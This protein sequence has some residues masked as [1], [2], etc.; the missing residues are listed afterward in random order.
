MRPSLWLP[1]LWPLLIVLNSSACGEGGG[2]A[3]SCD[4]DKQSIAA[5][6]FSLDTLPLEFCCVPGSTEEVLVG[7]IRASVGAEGTDP[8]YVRPNAT[9]PVRIEVREA[10][11]TEFREVPPGAEFTVDNDTPVDIRITALECFD[12]GLLEFDVFLYSKDNPFHPDREVGKIYRSVPLRRACPEPRP[13][14][15]TAVCPGTEEV[16]KVVLAATQAVSVAGTVCWRI[17]DGAT[18]ATISDKGSELG[19]PDS[20]AADVVAAA[21]I[22]AAVAIGPTGARMNQWLPGALAGTGGGAFGP[23]GYVFL[24]DNITDFVPYAGPG[25]AGGVF[26]NFT[27]G[28]VK[29]L[30]YDDGISYFKLHTSFIAAAA[31]PGATGK[32]I[33]AL[34]DGPDEDTFVVTDGTPGSLWVHRAADRPA[35][36]ATK[37]GDVEN[38]PR[39]LRRFGNLLVTSNFGSGS[40]TVARFDTRTIVRH[41]PVGNGPIGIDG[42]ILGNG[43]IAIVSTGFNDDTYTITVL[44]PQGDVVSSD[45]SPVPEGGLAPGHVIWHEDGILISCNGSSEIIF[46]PATGP[47]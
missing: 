3:C 6:E 8:L 28:E 34:A 2:P 31:L 30:V 43:Y 36:A 45:T 15:R 22:E 18:F 10:T 40:I 29:F 14:Q 9:V 4:P 24:S 7:T 26:S 19:Q 35:G 1:R 11:E 25:S 21:G 20:Y 42:K 38:D 47:S 44:T 46:V 17:L 32:A 33:S 41:V 23:T 12:E 13:V 16:R 37:I 5:R 39:R 27:R